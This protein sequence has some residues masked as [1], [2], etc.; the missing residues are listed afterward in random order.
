MGHSVG[1]V[2]VDEPHRCC[3]IEES[4]GRGNFQKAA[5]TLG[6]SPGPSLTT[7]M[8]DVPGYCRVGRPQ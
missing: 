8:V 1:E 4:W 6:Y 5:E 7:W 2:R 3:S